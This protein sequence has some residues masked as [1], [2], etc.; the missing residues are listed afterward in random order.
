MHKKSMN[1][2]TRLF[3]FKRAQVYLNLLLR[4]SFDATTENHSFSAKLRT[5]LNCFGLQVVFK[6][7]S[8]FTVTQCMCEKYVRNM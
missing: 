1:Y 5:Q 8:D 3:F 2:V 6:N 4:F 7:I